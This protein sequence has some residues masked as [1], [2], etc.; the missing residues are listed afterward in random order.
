MKKILI[1]FFIIFL[2]INNILAEDYDTTPLTLQNF[3]FEFDYN[4]QDLNLNLTNFNF[5]FD[6]IKQLFQFDLTQYISDYSRY[7]KLWELYPQLT[8]M[9]GY[10][11]WKEFSILENEPEYRMP[12]LDY[13]KFK[14]VAAKYK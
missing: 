13:Y 11:F 5:E 3:N 14:L 6:Y 8:G 7:K 2:S 12:K 10:E 1:F 4:F 9:S